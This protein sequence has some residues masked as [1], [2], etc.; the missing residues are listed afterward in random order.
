MNSNSDYWY[1]APEVVPD[2]GLYAA[3]NQF[4][5]PVHTSAAGTA[6]IKADQ[7]LLHPESRYIGAQNSEE[8]HSKE[9]HTEER[10]TGEQHP[11]K[12]NP[13]VGPSESGARKRVCGLAPRLFW[14]VL[15]IIAVV[16]VGAAVGVGVGVSLANRSQSV[17]SPSASSTSALSTTSISPDS[18]G[19][20]L[21]IGGTPTSTTTQSIS[22]STTSI[23]GPSTTLYRDCPSSDNTLHDITLGERTYTFRKFCSTV[24]L[25]IGDNSLVNQPTTDLNTCINKCALYNHQNASEI[26]A[27]DPVWY[28]PSLLPLSSFPLLHLCGI[29]L[30]FPYVASVTRCVGG[31]ISTSNPQAIVSASSPKTHRQGNSNLNS[32]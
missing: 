23:V 30:T 7:W 21:M 4:P 14:I 24:L 11:G 3:R 13:E 9:P 6:N 22:V 32:K 28:V 20:S 1:S 31:I 18:T 8:C 27:G 2:T 5:E 19:S 17:E 16:M 15:S 29:S 25:T 10:C 12:S 26:A